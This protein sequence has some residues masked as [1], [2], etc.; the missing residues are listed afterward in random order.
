MVPECCREDGEGVVVWEHIAGHGCENRGGY[1]GNEIGAG[2][3]RGCNAVQCLLSKE[4][5]DYLLALEGFVEE[6]SDEEWEREPGYCLSG[7]GDGLGSVE[8]VA[9]VW[10]PRHGVE[11]VSA[12]E[13][14]GWRE[15][16]MPFHPYC[17]EAYKRVSVLRR[18]WVDVVGLAGWWDREATRLPVHPA[19]RRGDDDSWY[20]EKGDEFLAANPIFVPRLP[21]IIEAARRLESDFD[22]KKS[23]FPEEEV[24]S[25]DGN[26]C[27]SKL[28]EEIRDTI[29]APLGSK[30][31]ANLRLASR[32]FRR[33]PTLLWH[34]L[35]QKEMPWFWEAWSDMPY[36]FWACTTKEEL[37]DH[38]RTMYARR[39]RVRKSTSLSPEEKKRQKGSLK[40]ED[41]AF[42]QPRA[43]ERLQRT[44]T[45]W[46]F[47]YRQ[48]KREW[49]KLKGLQ[50]RERIWTTLEYVVRRMDKPGESRDVTKAE[51]KKAHPFLEP[52][53][54]YR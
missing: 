38:D 23:P 40:A 21:A 24:K 52:G 18:G 14:D 34:D 32:T 45:D 35:T 25:A 9:G 53:W 48:I 33:L 8:Y 19:V 4:R 49:K 7:L 30:D 42:R 50:N 22:V 2:E 28:P 29:L 39:R 20:H 27:F 1:D 5:D 11:V 3:M 37:E 43:A 36:T 15:G 41:A 51:H 12:G 44:Q 6:E 16:S 31:I 13:W 54:Q 17:L 46:H 10:P 26:D 47:L